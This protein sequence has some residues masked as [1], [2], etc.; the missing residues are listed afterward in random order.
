MGSRLGTATLV[1]DSPAR[2]VG[3]A[4][5]VGNK[6]GRGP[7]GASFD[8]VLG[9]DD[10]YGEKS[11]EL[12][13]RKMYEQAV[14][15]AV[16]KAGIAVQSLNFLVGGDLLNQIISASF[17]ARDLGVPFI[18]LYNACST[19]AESLIVAAM[20]ID[21]GF[22]ERT[23]CAV[24]SHF[25]SAERQYRMPLE[26][27]T[28]RTPT[29]QWTVTGAGCTLLARDGDGMPAVTMGTVG[30]VV[31][32]GV[33][34]ANNMGAAMAPAAADCLKTHFADTG[35]TPDDYDLIVTGDLG[36]V[37]KDILAELMRREGICLGGNYIDCGC[38]IFSPA[39][40]THA[41]G[42]GCGCSAS[43]LN[44]WLLGRL[45]RGEVK[46]MLFMATGAL[47]SP[48][49]SMQGESIPSVAHAVVIESREK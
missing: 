9:K 13:E 29:Q 7:L 16:S 43:V 38:E 2:A 11:W 36:G 14:E 46:R 45:A 19:M 23:A 5:V 24:S 10:T 31:D 15:L 35:R 34:D 40:D 44:G 33:K 30:R 18:G 17:A 22:A 37:G 26:L 39:Q 27:G 20:L 21:G 48:T 47:M 25:S 42:S 4:S 28:Q 1:F 32:Y 12:A 8:I 49:S 3:W 41:G 6:E